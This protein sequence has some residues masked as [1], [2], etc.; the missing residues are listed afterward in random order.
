[1]QG[2]RGRS[3]PPHCTGNRV[4]TSA[5][6]PLTSTVW[7]GTSPWGRKAE[8]ELPEAEVQ[9][10]PCIPSCSTFL[11]CFINST[12][13]VTALWAATRPEPQAAAQHRRSPA[14]P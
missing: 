7:L 8:R 10:L 1:M 9:V 13:N 6:M 14:G 3:V 4:A 5:E 11:L 12:A 2:A